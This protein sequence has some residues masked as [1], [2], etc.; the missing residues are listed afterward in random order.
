MRRTI[1]LLYVFVVVVLF[2]YGVLTVR[3]NSPTR[4]LE[5]K[6]T[7]TSAHVPIDQPYEIATVAAVIDGDTIT[8]ADKRKLRYI[9]ID[10]PE[11]KHPTK[12]VQCFGLEA[13]KKNRELVE[14]KTIRMQKDV[15]ETDRYG[16][17]L[18][19]VWVGDVFVNDSLVRSG[20][21]HQA[22]FPPDVR[23]ATQF[24]NAAEE[25]RQKNRGLWGVCQ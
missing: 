13:S 23:F 18:R 8:L 10:T 25:A 6:P 3:V 1:T 9:G 21:A 17:L 24:R 5:Q 22:T 15:S 4:V 14:G 7:P 2:S 11:T 19:Y 12:G 16:R 20:F